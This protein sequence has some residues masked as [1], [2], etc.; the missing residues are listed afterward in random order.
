MLLAYQNIQKYQFQLK[1]RHNQIDCLGMLHMLMHHQ[2]IKHFQELFHSKNNHKLQ[3]VFHEFLNYV[4]HSI[5]KMQHLEY[6]HKHHLLDQN[7]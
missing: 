1:L 6:I 2:Q 7:K 3:L 4:L 5:Q